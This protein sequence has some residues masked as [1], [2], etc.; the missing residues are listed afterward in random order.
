MLVGSPANLVASSTTNHGVGVSDVQYKWSQ[1]TRPT[2]ALISNATLK[3]VFVTP[4]EPGTYVF[5]VE[6]TITAGFVKKET[7]S[8]TVSVVVTEPTPDPE[9]E[10]ETGTGT[11]NWNWCRRQLRRHYG[12]RSQLRPTGPHGQSRKAQ[13]RCGG[14]PCPQFLS[15]GPFNGC[16]Q[17]TA[18]SKEPCAF[19][20]LRLPAHAEVS[21]AT[22]M[23]TK[24]RSQKWLV[25][26]LCFFGIDHHVFDHSLHLSGKGDSGPG[27]AAQAQADTISAIRTAAEILVFEHYVDYRRASPLFAMASPSPGVKALHLRFAPQ[28][29]NWRK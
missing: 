20:A 14:K 21:R 19:L 23:M 3:S 26:D 9:T 18:Q 1:L 13:Q 7:K 28:W 5:L 11:G 17:V 22:L 2:N 27:D 15:T 10:T 24:R 16:E 25:H 12:H 6:S 4:P 29:L 8:A